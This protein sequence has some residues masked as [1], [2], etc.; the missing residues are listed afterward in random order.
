MTM[1]GSMLLA[2]SAFF[3]SHFVATTFATPINSHQSPDL[4]I[5]APLVARQKGTYSG[6]DANVD[7]NLT[8]IYNCFRGG[9][10]VRQ[11]ELNIPINN[12]C[13]EP[14]YD[15]LEFTPFSLTPNDDGAYPPEQSDY[16]LEQGCFD[17]SHACDDTPQKG[18]AY[19]HFNAD[20]RGPTHATKAYC[21]YALGRVRDLCHGEN[22]WTR[23]GW[24]TFIDE[25]SY[26]LD[27]SRNGK[28]Q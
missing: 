12:I 7:Q 27:P 8:G 2:S 22:G 11:T 26:G 28:D 4:S 21:E 24:F 1:A 17:V 9:T 6:T 20:I 5:T 15:V 18:T 16:Q 3:I 14:V 13:G 10:W 25:T 19:V 23:G